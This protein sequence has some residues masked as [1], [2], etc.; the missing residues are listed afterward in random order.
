MS[1]QTF[2]KTQVPEIAQEIIEKI[3]LENSAM[4]IT[5]SGDLGTGKTT[6]TQNIAREL[7]VKEKV[8]SP[9]FVIMKMYDLKNQ[10]HKQLVHID[11]YRLTSHNELTTLGFRQIISNPENLVLIEWPENV[12]ELIPA[13]AEKILL[14]HVDEDTREIIF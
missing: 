1:N 13:N 2:N 14:K 5:L 11:A 10:K 7:G 6:L 12:K 9:T 8:I 3:T 4:V